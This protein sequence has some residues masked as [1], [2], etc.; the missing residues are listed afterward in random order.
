GP[1]SGAMDIL[2]IVY[3]YL[4]AFIILG[5]IIIFIRI[6]SRFLVGKPSKPQAPPVETPTAKPEVREEAPKQIAADDVK[7]AIAAVA[8]HLS[9]QA[10]R[11]S[12]TIPHVPQQLTQ[13][14]V[15]QWR[16]QVSKSLNEL[17]LIKYIYRKTRL[18]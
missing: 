15:N 3:A 2:A 6:S 1:M 11:S 4:L 17:C 14:W 12:L 13:P 18:V 5:I 9:L 16:A 8:A 7:A 10:V